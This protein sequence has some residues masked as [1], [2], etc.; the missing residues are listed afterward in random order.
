MRVEGDGRRVSVRLF[1]PV[2][3][4]LHYPLVPDMQAVK[5]AKRQHRRLH[6]VSVLE[7]VEYLHLHSNGISGVPARATDWPVS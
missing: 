1:C 6:D 4:T 7:A 5:N 2:D 3:D